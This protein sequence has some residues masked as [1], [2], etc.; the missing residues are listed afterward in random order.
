[1]R[2]QPIGYHF[3]RPEMQAS[4]NDSPVPCLRFDQVVPSFDAATSDPT[5]RGKAIGPKGK[6]L[7]VKKAETLPEHETPARRLP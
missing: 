2:A 4:K 6:E 1:M 7:R 3:E 5:R